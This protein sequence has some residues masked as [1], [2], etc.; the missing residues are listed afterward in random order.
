MSDGKRIIPGYKNVDGHYIKEPVATVPLAPQALKEILT[1]GDVSIDDLF[2]KGLLAIHRLMSL[3]NQE[4]LIGMPERD[5]VA[6]LKDCMAMLEALKKR[7]QDL[8]EKMS[9]EELEEYTKAL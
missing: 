3:I 4:I 8:I 2:K 5:T 1:E 6:N 7:E 9:D